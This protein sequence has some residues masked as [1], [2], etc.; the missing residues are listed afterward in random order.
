MHAAEYL[1]STGAKAFAMAQYASCM[2]TC[3]HKQVLMHFGTPIAELT[4]CKEACDN[5]LRSSKGNCTEHIVSGTAT[6]IRDLF[7]SELVRDMGGLHG[8]DCIINSLRGSAS[9][10]E[11]IKVADE[12]RER[13]APL[14]GKQR[15]VP[16]D[17][18]KAVFGLM[19]AHGVLR[20]VPVRNKHNILEWSTNLRY[21]VS[22]PTGLLHA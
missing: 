3:R 14:I 9:A 11:V 6:I 18:V 19:L 4:D 10:T 5:C 21:S 12:D 13:L 1:E 2:T 16:K 15:G 7:Q 20:G 17:V 22:V 8:I